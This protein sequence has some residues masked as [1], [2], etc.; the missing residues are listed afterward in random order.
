MDAYLDDLHRQFIQVI[1]ESHAAGNIDLYVYSEITPDLVLAGGV[2]STTDDEAVPLS[3]TTS[4][5]T[6]WV[7]VFMPTVGNT[8]YTLTVVDDT[9]ESYAGQ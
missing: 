4:G 8:S 2:Q 9:V 6:Y 5:A 1:F 3:S 7:R